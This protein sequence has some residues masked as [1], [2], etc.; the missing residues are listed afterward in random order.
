M[1][2]NFH[3]LCYDLLHETMDRLIDAAATCEAHGDVL[4]IEPRADDDDRDATKL[5]KAQ[6]Q[7]G[8]GDDELP[9]LQQIIGHLSQ[10][11]IINGARQ[12]VLANGEDQSIHTTPKQ[13]QA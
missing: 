2:S 1:E 11:L 7:V 3:D 9:H 4:S 10:L 12:L 13:P 8:G 6:L 5:M